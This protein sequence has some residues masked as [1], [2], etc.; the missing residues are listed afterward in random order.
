LALFRSTEIV[1][2]GSRNSTEIFNETLYNYRKTAAGGFWIRQ[3]GQSYV[4]EM[5]EK[6]ERGK[7]RLLLQHRIKDTTRRQV[8]RLSFVNEYLILP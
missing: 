7:I 1:S 8:A 4:V 3:I 5:R 2:L 6:N